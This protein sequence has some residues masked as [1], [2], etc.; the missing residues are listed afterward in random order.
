MSFCNWFDKHTGCLAALFWSSVGLAVVG[1]L[2]WKWLHPVTVDDP[3]FHY[4]R[5]E[6]LLEVRD[7]DEAIKAYDE[8][9]RLDPNDADFFLGRGF[10][11]FSKKDFDKAIVDYSEAICLDP[12]Y[13]VAFWHRGRAWASKKRF[14]QA[15]KDYEE[16]IRLDPKDGRFYGDLAWLLA[17][18]E[19]ENVRDGKRALQLATK[20]CELGF[21]DS[22]PE[23]EALAAA[24]AELG[25]FGEAKRY[26]R[27]A[28]G[29]SGFRG[30]DAKD[31]L[32]R[33]QLYKQKQ[34][35]RED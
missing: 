28:I 2:G 5:G 35:Y 21:W 18:C 33:L 20:G 29:A 1:W 22:G 15:I 30:S 10:G 24:Y 14:G 9:I 16:A 32:K 4:S 12:E 7:F 25:Q 3:F 23:L 27:K 8:A 19:D 13:A 31:Q 6:H 11:W 26:Q 34:P 17:T